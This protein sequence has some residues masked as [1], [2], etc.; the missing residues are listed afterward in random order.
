MGKAS[1]ETGGDHGVNGR[2]RRRNGRKWKRRAGRGER[3]RGPGKSGGLCPQFSLRPPPRILVPSCPKFPPYPTPRQICS[4]N[5]LFSVHLLL[6]RY[7]ENASLREPH[8]FVELPVPKPLKSVILCLGTVPG[9][10]HNAAEHNE[11]SVLKGDTFPGA[12]P[13]PCQAPP[14]P[15]RA[16]HTLFL[17]HVAPQPPGEAK[18]WPLAG[19]RDVYLDRAKL[20]FGFLLFCFSGFKLDTVNHVKTLVS[21]LYSSDFWRSCADPV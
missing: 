7:L 18:D 4:Q 11:G 21:F 13:A 9:L 12:T 20:G 2:R 3:S 19:P 1:R 8:G 15:W 14:S 17:S 5:S 10:S 6:A 16:P